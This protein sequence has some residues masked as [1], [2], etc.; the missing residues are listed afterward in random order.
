MTAGDGG[1]TDLPDLLLALVNH[2]FLVGL[3]TL[4]K[5]EVKEDQN[6]LV[7]FTHLEFESSKFNCPMTLSSLR[8][9]EPLELALADDSR[10]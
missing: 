2:F 5:H 9:L 4:Q 7:H 8:M 3:P 10:F 6:D 1:G